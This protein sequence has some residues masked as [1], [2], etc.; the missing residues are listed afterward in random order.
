LVSLI[1]AVIP[2][3]LLPYLQDAAV[4]CAVCS[5]GNCG[6][7]AA[8]SPTHAHCEAGV[9]LA[10]SGYVFGRIGTQAQ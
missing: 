7:A 1:H 3:G 2:A 6:F 8:N 10:A 5:W 4:A 9:Q